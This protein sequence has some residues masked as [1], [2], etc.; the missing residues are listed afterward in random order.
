MHTA[1]AAR[2]RGPVTDT[3]GVPSTIITEATDHPLGAAQT[4][5][6]P[7]ATAAH[8][9]RI[10]LPVQDLRAMQSVTGGAAPGRCAVRV[11]LAGV[12]RGSPGSGDVAGAAAGAGR[13]P[14]RRPRADRGRVLRH[15][16]VPDAGVGAAP[17]GRWH[18]H[19]AGNPERGWDA[20]VIGEYERAFCSS[21]YASMAPLLEHY[22]VQ[23]G[24]P[25]VGGRIDFRAEDHEETI[26]LSSSGTAVCRSTGMPSARLA[27]SRSRRRAAP[28][29][30]R[31]PAS[32]A[33]MAPARSTAAIGVVPSL[34]LTPVV[35]KGRR[36]SGAA[37]RWR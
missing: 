4:V 31:C 33:L 24:T 12:D 30:S 23:L 15:R 35:M 18:G 1:E 7:T 5:M 14:G 16:A 36:S 32:S 2:G 6:R 19:R 27:A 26:A 29:H 13:R 34:M 28:E 8:I 3:P 21:Q 11:L 37:S 10:F 22:G 17:A 20:V 25:E 9:R